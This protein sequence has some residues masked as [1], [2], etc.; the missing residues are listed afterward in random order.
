MGFNQYIIRN[1]RKFKEIQRAICIDV[2]GL[3]KGSL[4]GFIIENRIVVGRVLTEPDEN[5]VFNIKIPDGK[6]KAK[7]VKVKATDF[8]DDMFLGVEILETIKYID[9][10]I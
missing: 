1:P 10:N 8:E 4:A 2:Y 9:L 3:I 5:L 7:E 6:G